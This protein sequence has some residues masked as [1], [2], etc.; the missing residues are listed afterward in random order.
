MRHVDYLRFLSRHLD[1][2]TNEAWQF[3]QASC[4]AAR[5]VHTLWLTTMYSV[6]PELISP[7]HGTKAF[8][9]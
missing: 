7:L 6:P 3:S 2:P 1:V 8:R 9:V 5:S 4:L